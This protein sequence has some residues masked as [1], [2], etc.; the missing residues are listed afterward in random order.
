MVLVDDEERVARLEQLAEIER[1]LLP[2]VESGDLDAT[3]EWLELLEEREALLGGYL[4]GQPAVDD[5]ERE[6]LRQDALLQYAKNEVVLLDQ[7]QTP[8]VVQV[9]ADLRRS[10]DNLAGLDEPESP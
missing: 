8:K 1:L 2:R 4:S 5:E 6:Q 10:R 3:E 9:L 7:P